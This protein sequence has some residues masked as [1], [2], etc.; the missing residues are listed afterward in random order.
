[1]SEAPR[2][3]ALPLLSV[4]AWIVPAGLRAQ[5]HAEWVGEMSYYWER[6]GVTPRTRLELYRRAGG[7]LADALW[8]RRHHGG[9]QMLGRDLH[10][11]LRSLARRPA[12]T[13]VVVLTLALGI[14]ATTSIFSVVHGVLLRSLPYGKPERLVTIVGVPTD[15]DTAK[16]ASAASHPDFVDYR[17]AARSFEQMAA[18]RAWAWTLTG[19][20]M[21]PTVLEGAAITANLLPTLRVQPA[22]GRNFLPEEERPGGARLVILGDALWRG[23]FG[24]DPA[25]L[26]R[27]VTIDAMPHTVVGVMPR[28]FEFP[29][30]SQLWIPLVPERVEE[31]RGVHRYGLLARLAPSA[32]LEGASA[33]MRGIARR[34]ELQYPEDNAKRTVRLVPLHDRIVRNIRPALLVLFGAVVVMLLIVCA[35]VANL[36]LARAAAREREVAV[37]AAL[38]AG[39]GTLV[40]QF[41]TESV[42][43][44]VLGGLGGVLV[45][46]WGTRLLVGSA[47]LEIPRVGE[48][49]IDA[50]VLGF[51]LLVSLGTGIAFGLAPALQYTR[52]G[53]FGGLREG[54]GTTGSAARRRV[55]HTL[56]VAEVAL[57]VVLVIGAGL[58]AKSFRQLQ[59]VDLGFDSTGLLTAHVLPPEARYDTREKVRAFYE[60]LRSRLR[61]TP[62]ISEVAISMEHPLSPG[63]TTSFTIEGRPAPL[64][65]HEPEARIRPVMPGYFRTVGIRLLRGRDIAETDRAES[66][67]V[68]VINESFARRHFPGED[69]IGRRLL[70]NPWWDGMPRSFEIIG[71]AADERYLGLDQET[72]PATYFAF[73]HFPLNNMYVTLRTDGDPLALVPSLRRVIWSLDRDLPLD[74]I[75]TMDELLAESLAAPRFNATLLVLFAGIALLLAAIGIYGVLAFSVAQRTSEI[76]IRIALGAP[77]GRVVAL[78]VRQ[79]VLLTGV[80]L[81]LGLIVAGWTTGALDRLLYRVSATDPVVFASVAAVLGLVALVAAY[82]PARR[83]SRIDPMIALKAE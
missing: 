81:A 57:A 35:N 77:R 50:T 60:E 47:P 10:Y 14:G 48:I 18:Y 1:M 15:E 21:N 45:A 24:G 78:V 9:E 42:V 82:L 51:A 53:S 68:V 40:R 41:L 19:R 73:A 17:A 63:W 20:E 16:V 56:V 37:R 22:L 54:R 79:A 30:R 8:L 32:T 43:I 52:P 13:A 65:G 6:R 29:G 80:G 7:A 46:Y 36:V 33:E 59:H 62:G 12:F 25:I 4:F 70:R 23:R 28:G 26:G 72:D 71:V 44:A 75:R 5:W 38:G 69:P 58:L 49:G 66:P 27:T 31:N 76:G 39:R 11:A 83:A 3:P 64:P 55:R 67:G 34:L 2:V 74:E 61:A